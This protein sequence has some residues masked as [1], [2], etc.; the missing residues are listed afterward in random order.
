MTVLLAGR[1]A[2]EM[3]FGETSSGAVDDLER[4]T[5]L[6]HRMVTQF[7][8]GDRVGPVSLEAGA[9][10]TPGAPFQGLYGRSE[11]TARVVDEE[12]RG[13]VEEAHA[14]ALTLLRE[15]EGSLRILA[16]ELRERE[17]VEGAELARR[18]EELGCFRGEHMGSGTDTSPVDRSL[19]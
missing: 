5:E 8:M 13:L 10:G 16:A 12:V 4:A 19:P 2:E 3:I 11:H 9:W 14:R 1:A 18:M 17:S 15:N 6:A 7:G